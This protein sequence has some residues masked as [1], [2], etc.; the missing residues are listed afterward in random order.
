MIYRT[1]LAPS[2]DVG[3]AMAKAAWEVIEKESFPYI[4]PAVEAVRAAVKA[5]YPQ[6]S[7]P[8]V[9][10]KHGKKFFRI[11]YDYVTETDYVD[12]S[13]PYAP[14][15]HAIKKVRVV[16]KHTFS[17]PAGAQVLLCSHNNGGM[18]KMGTWGGLNAPML[19]PSWWIWADK[20]APFVPD[21]KKDFFSLM[22][23]G[24]R[25]QDDNGF[26]IAT[27]ITPTTINVVEV[28]RGWQAKTDSK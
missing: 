23:D 17:V 7:G 12:I 14:R 16:G 6:V 24:F 28:E 15:I 11:E 10:I 1:L 22:G 26:E 20:S 4:E 21:G 13:H 18:V 5:V 19:Q 2:E 3:K 25:F 27:A 9:N 8:R